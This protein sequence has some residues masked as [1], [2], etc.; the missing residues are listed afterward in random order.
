[1][2]PK[3]SLVGIPPGATGIV[4][5]DSRVLQNPILTL[6]PWVAELSLDPGMGILAAGVQACASSEIKAGQIA[7]L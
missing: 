2:P 7:I 6:D 1:M 4:F 5:S 3:K